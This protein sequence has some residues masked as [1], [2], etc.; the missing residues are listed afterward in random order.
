MRVY[1]L[2]AC[3]SVVY[4]YVELDWVRSQAV[5]DSKGEPSR[6]ATVRSARTE[7]MDRTGKWNELVIVWTQ[8]RLA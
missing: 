2:L 8:C 3:N 4:P 6:Q 1:A 7:K 5:A